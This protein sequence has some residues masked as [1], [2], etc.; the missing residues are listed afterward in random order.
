M[1]KAALAIAAIT[2]VVAVAGTVPIASAS[3]A[4]PAATSKSLVFSVQFSPFFALHFHPNPDPSTTFG[5]GD[6]I[7]FH[8]Q[9]FSDHQHAGD[10]GG[11]CVII[12]GSQALANCTQVIRLQQGTITAQFLNAPAPRKQL[13]VTGG[14]GIYRD[15]GGEGTLVEFGNG[16]GRLT[17]HLLD[18]RT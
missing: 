13:A 8:D 16:T 11:S 17:L 6:E 7:T 3:T 15:A 5:P 14:T 4:K 10:E 12:D 18:P 1:R 9:L 2:V